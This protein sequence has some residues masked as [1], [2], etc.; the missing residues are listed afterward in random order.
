MLV[1]GLTEF[2]ENRPT[3]SLDTLTASYP[4]TP[5]AELARQILDWRQLHPQ[6]VPPLV[7]R[8][9]AL[10]TELREIKAENQRL[11]SDI[12]KLQRLLI[13]SERN[14]R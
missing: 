10:N 13:D 14:L 3:A 9:A 7:A 6:L 2:L 5:Q 12:K 11:R 8:K 4:A 1:A